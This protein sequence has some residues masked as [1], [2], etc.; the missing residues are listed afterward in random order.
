MRGAAGKE[1]GGAVGATF[2]KDPCGN[3]YRVEHDAAVIEASVPALRG[4][5]DAN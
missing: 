3:S 1:G 5:Q 4:Y 2:G